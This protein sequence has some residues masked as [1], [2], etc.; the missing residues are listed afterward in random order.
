MNRNLYKN[1]WNATQ[2]YLYFYN[3]TGDTSFNK[4]ESSTQTSH[5]FNEN[6][7]ITSLN[8]VGDVHGVWQNV[9]VTGL[10][11]RFHFGQT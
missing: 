11:S 3:L 1:L 8:N 6:M 7:L 2:K 4:Y 5:A 9:T 10:L